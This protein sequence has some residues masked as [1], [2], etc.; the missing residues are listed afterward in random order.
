MHR[1]G[2]S[3]IMAQN[4][5]AVSLA[6]IVLAA[7]ATLA[8]TGARAD[9]LDARPTA[10]SCAETPPLAG[11]RSKGFDGAGSRDGIADRHTSTGPTFP[12]ICATE[13]I[14]FLSPIQ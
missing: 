12:S 11:L 1:D 13:F 5:A 4:T 14:L 8:G 3:S 7:F 10:V 6:V 9:D 2:R